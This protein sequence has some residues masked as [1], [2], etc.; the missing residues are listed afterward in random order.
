MKFVDQLFELLGWR[1]TLGLMVAL[2]LLPLIIIVVTMSL[3]WEATFSASARTEVVEFDTGR[4]NVPNWF[5]EFERLRI[6]GLDFEPFSGQLEIGADTLVRLVRFQTGAV[7]L[8]LER[9][10]SGPTAVIYDQAENRV[11]IVEQRLQAFISLPAGRAVSFPV[12]GRAVIG[13]TVFAQTIET[14]PVLLEGHV[15]AFGL[16]AIGRNRFAAQEARL[17]SGDRL[18][19]EYIEP[20]FGGHGMIRIEP[21]LP[22]LHV[23]FHADGKSVR[24]IRFGTA[25]YEL[26]PSVWSRIS[27]DPLYQSLLAIYAVLLPAI[28]LAFVSLLN[29]WRLRQFTRQPPGPKPNPFSNDGSGDLQSVDRKPEQPPAK[30]SRD[31]ETE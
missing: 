28:G 4:H 29:Q 21:D 17:D 30:T 16:Y 5:V 7:R 1:A 15:Q 27:A 22:G 31:D 11:A 9:R 10:E 25:G 23:V 3:N 6:D 13:D 2:A 19:M 8:T 12:A 18:E 24:I 14:S 20:G 26:S